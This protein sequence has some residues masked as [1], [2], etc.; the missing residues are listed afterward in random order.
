M[1][2]L[3]NIFLYN[4]NSKNKELYHQYLEN[5]GYFIFDTDNIHKFSLYNK[6]ITPDILLFDFDKNT[7]CTLISSI[8]RQFE[9]SNTPIIIVSESPKALI[10][11]PTISH[12]LTHIEAKTKLI[13]ILESYKIGNKNHHILYINLKPYERQDFTK[14]IEQKGYL[15]FE[16]HNIKSASLYLQKNTPSIICINFLPALEKTKK[17]FSHPKIFYV[18]NSQNVEEIEQFLH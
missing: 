7:P 12:Y 9:H 4:N 15:L 16:V 2:T 17:L 11:H 3:G 14:S 1:R 18:E 13:E 8:E 6:E 10:Y 5:Q